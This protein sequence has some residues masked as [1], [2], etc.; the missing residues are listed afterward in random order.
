MIFNYDKNAN[1]KSNKNNKINELKKANIPFC[2]NVNFDQPKEMIFKSKVSYKNSHLIKSK[3]FCD[4]DLLHKM[5][6]NKNRNN[7]KNLNKNQ[8]LTNEKFNHINQK[9]N[10]NFFRQNIDN[11]QNINKERN[12]KNKTTGKKENINKKETK[13]NEQFEN[14][15]SEVSCSLFNVLYSKREKNEKKE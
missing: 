4:Q 5:K 12:E 8:Y 1:K 2:R 10:K 9:A 14:S 15:I 13:A 7:K 11:S 6:K 3:S